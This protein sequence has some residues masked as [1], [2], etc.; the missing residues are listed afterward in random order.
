MAAV[1]KGFQAK[2][3]RAVFPYRADFF[4]A[5]LPGKNHG[6]R[7]ELVQ[8][9]RRLTVENS[10]LRADMSGTFRR[11][12]LRHAKEPEIR[13]DQRVRPQILQE[14]KVV[15]NQLQF[16]LPREH[17][18]GDIRLFPLSMDQMDGPLKILILKI[19]RLGTHA[20]EPARKIDGIRP[21]E[22][23]RLNPIQIPRRGQ[24]FRKLHV[25]LP[26]SER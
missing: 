8:K 23:R 2:L 14:R 11:I 9:R 21:V 7:A 16:L 18:A 3:R 5:A 1:D 24:Q 17:I 13:Q 15:R 26:M 22:Q 12:P 19:D 10:E 20:K 25:S 6:I 4:Q